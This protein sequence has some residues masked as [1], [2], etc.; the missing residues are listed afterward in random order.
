MAE[1]SSVL[2]VRFFA[3]DLLLI[4]LLLRSVVALTDDG[5]VLLT[6]KSAV[7]EDPDHALAAWRDRDA[8]PCSWPGVSCR[9]GRLSLLTDLET[10]A[11]PRNRLSGHIPPA[12]AALRSLTTLDLSYNFLS[13]PIPAGIG[14]LKSLAHLDLSSNRLNGTLPPSIATLPRL[15]GIL[16]LSSNL[17]SGKIPM[18]YGEILFVVSLDLRHNN[19][20]DEI[21]QSGSLLNQGPTAFSGNPNLCGFPLRTP[22]VASNQNPNMPKPSPR[23]TLNPSTVNATPVEVEGKRRPAV[24]IP[25][26]AAVVA[27]AVL[28]V[29]VLQWQLRR[30]R[31]DG[32]EKKDGEKEERRGGGEGEVYVAVDD[33]FVMELE[34]LL[35]ASAYVVGKS[36]GGIVYKVVAGRAPAVAVRRLSEGEDGDSGGGSGDEWRRRRA[37]EAEAMAIGRARHPNVVSLRAYYY[38]QD[39]KLLIYDYISN[40]SLHSHLHGELN[41]TAVPLSWAVRLGIIKGVARGLA[42][43]HECSPRKYVHGNIKSSKI[44]VDDDFNPYV[45]GFGLIR[46]FSGSHKLAHSTSKKLT[47]AHLAASASPYLAPEARTPGS[48]ITQKCDVYAFGIILLEVLTGRLPG[49]KTDDD[50]VDLEGFVRRAFKEERPLSEV[51]DPSLLHEVYAKKQVLAVFHV[52]LGCTES[53][54]ESRPRMRAVSESLDRIGESQ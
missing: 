36:R 25:I 51:V 13:G 35:R 41:Q 44:L 37:F 4:L 28:A 5:L 8:S 40:G 33:G 11:L 49:S 47:S 2:V 3:G 42:Y 26:L 20:S 21:P 12:I 24:T 32:E 15:A 10:L 34:E 30:R 43:L 39:E 19:L 22:C 7:A 31:S 1:I 6:L 52:A 9:H 23:I 53:D 18:E 14:D 38:A 27:A 16:N 29:V 45:S 50:N 48:L 17:I 54:P 46:L